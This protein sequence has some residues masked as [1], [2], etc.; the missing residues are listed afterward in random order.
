M[1]DILK[2]LSESVSEECFED[3][4]SII[5]EIINGGDESNPVKKERRNNKTKVYRRMDNPEKNKINVKKYYNR[6]IH[7]DTGFE[8]DDYIKI[9]GKKF[10][11]DK[12]GQIGGPYSQPGAHSPYH[13]HI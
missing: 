10:H 6:V 9:K 5:E 12:Y 11:V 7:N 8:C 13:M 1:E 2:S 3:I 4:L